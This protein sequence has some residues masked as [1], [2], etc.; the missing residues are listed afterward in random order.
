MTQGSRGGGRR[1]RIIIDVSSAQGAARKKSWRESRVGRYLSVTAL[2]I[3]GV[4]L[5]VLV[6]GYAWWRS[7]EK[8]PAYSLALLVEAAQRDDKQ[9]VESLIDSD[10]I[11]DGFVPQI[12]NAFASQNPQITPQARAQLSN[13]IPLLLPRVRETM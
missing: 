2:V 10:K 11:A 6:A 3:I 12:I 1:S 7:F 8:S 13:L 9:A 4:V 5:V